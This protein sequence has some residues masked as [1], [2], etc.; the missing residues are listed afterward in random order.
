MSFGRD[1]LQ[2][3]ILSLSF[4]WTVSCENIYSDTQIE[5]QLSLSLSL[6]L[7]LI[8]CFFFFLI[9]LFN[10]IAARF[11][12]RFVGKRNHQHYKRQVER[13]T[14]QI[15]R[16]DEGKSITC[17]RVLLVFSS[18]RVCIFMSTLRTSGYFHT[19]KGVQASLAF[20]YALASFLFTFL[21][22]TRLLVLYF[23]LL[24]LC[25]P[26]MQSRTESLFLPCKVNIKDV[27]YSFFSY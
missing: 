16:E 6:S 5:N 12:F 9:I 19:T 26:K 27:H 15:E 11:H 25:L 2:S 10:N 1:L 8:A 20:A 18:C 13:V 3:I 4:T 7:S 21:S 17:S 22:Y 24:I 14:K 23:G